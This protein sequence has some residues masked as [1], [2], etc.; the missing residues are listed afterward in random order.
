M[1]SFI[2]NLMLIIAGVI[3]LGLSYTWKK[4]VSKTDYD[5]FNLKWCFKLGIIS[6]AGGILGIINSTSIAPFGYLYYAYNLLNFV[7]LIVGGIFAYKTLKLLN[8]K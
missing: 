6:L 8:T 2:L 1:M 3:L 7:L 4:K 5:K